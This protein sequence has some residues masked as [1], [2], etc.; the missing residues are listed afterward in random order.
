LLTAVRFSLLILGVIL[1]IGAGADLLL[2]TRYAGDF[3][4]ER[5]FCRFELCNSAEWLELSQGGLAKNQT[6]FPVGAVSRYRFLL[7]RDPNYPFRWAD[8]GDALDAGHSREVAEYCFR[9]AVA[10]APHWPPVL[11]RAATYYFR[12]GNA[13]A[14]FPLTSQS[15]DRVE[16]YDAYIFALYLNQA[17][18]GQTKLP[19]VMRYGFPVRNPRPARSFLRYAIQKGD[20]AATRTAWSWL[21]EKG[22]AN[23]QSVNDYVNFLLLQHSPQEASSVWKQYLGSSAGDYGKSNDVFNGGFESAPGASAL[24]WII[25]LQKGTQVIRD[26]KTF[27]AGHWALRIAFDGTQNLTDT[28]VKQIVVLSKGSYRF[29][30]RI[31]TE[32]ITTGEGIYFELLPL[33]QA[34]LCRWKSTKWAGTNP[35]STVDVSFTVPGEGGAY[36]IRLARDESIKLDNLLAGTVWIDSIGITPAPH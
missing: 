9:Q 1:V 6:V 21:N 18:L 31:R 17:S 24:D 32:E 34:S 2:T 30:A 12:S 19:D 5:N 7:E 35:W 22:F 27:D 23:A 25:T 11:M 26:D 20:A 29:S 10:L 33:D 15:L 14:A 8:L 16:Q 4:M 13:I 36:L 28:G 3:E